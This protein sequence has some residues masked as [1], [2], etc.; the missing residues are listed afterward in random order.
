MPA[1][2]IADRLEWPYSLGPLKKRLALIRPEYVGID[3]ADRTVYRPGEITECDLW[4]PPT[5][6][7]VG[8]HEARVLPVLVMTNAYSRYLSGVMLP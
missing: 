7:P 5:K 8:A 6:V 4:F 1:P 2:V 3:P